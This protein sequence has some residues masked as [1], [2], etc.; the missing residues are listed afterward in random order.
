MI[1]GSGAATV[2][3]KSTSTSSGISSNR[4]DAICW[5]C[6]SSWLIAFGVK[7]WL[8]ILRRNVCRTPSAITRLSVRGPELSSRRISVRRGSR[9]SISDRC[10]APAA[11]VT[12]TW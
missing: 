10:P 4:S 8:A 9:A 11:A 12:Y 7:A 6:A 1:I 5:T 3:T 2:S